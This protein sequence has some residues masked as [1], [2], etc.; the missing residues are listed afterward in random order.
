M[1]YK[2]DNKYKVCLAT[3]APSY[4]ASLI[5]NS[6][7]TNYAG[8]SGPAA[9]LADAVS[10]DVVT[11][12]AGN[13][14]TAKILH[15][16]QTLFIVENGGTY[17]G[18]VITDAEGY[19]VKAEKT[20][21]KTAYTVVADNAVAQIVGF[22]DTYGSVG[23]AIK[24]AADGATIKLL[25]NLNNSAC[26]DSY[27]QYK[28]S[29]TLDLNGKSLTASDSPLRLDNLNYLNNTA[30]QNKTILLTG[31]GTVTATG[32]LKEGLIAPIHL[33]ADGTKLIIENG[34]YT[35]NTGQRVLYNYQSFCTL[36]VNGGTF[37]G[38]IEHYHGNTSID[39]GNFT[40]NVRMVNKGTLTINGGTFNGDIYSTEDAY[41][42]EMYIN[43]GIFNG[44][45][46]MGEG[47]VKNFSISG[48]KFKVKPDA[49]YLAP[50]ATCSDTPDEDGYYVVTSSN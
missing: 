41:K 25:K 48:G 34:T 40:G 45:I 31:N 24:A 6:K 4:T 46:Q 27:Y 7:T 47:Y 36:N 23:D 43:G 38:D 8:T 33:A 22:E 10:E 11:L 15:K 44:S 37:V 32:N 18:T 30:E 16:D 19:I 49:S 20:G 9:A 42:C 50:G 26:I 17:A 2:E 39:A 1:T 12:L 13:L 3:E 5:S 14:M 21:N 29:F 35:V 28:K